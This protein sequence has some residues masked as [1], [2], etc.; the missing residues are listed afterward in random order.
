V[1]TV[2][3]GGDILE[4]KFNYFLMVWKNKHYKNISKSIKRIVGQPLLMIF[5]KK[6]NY[7]RFLRWV[8]LTVSYK[9]RYE[10][11]LRWVLLTISYKKPLGKVF[12]LGFA[13]GYL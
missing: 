7:E 10:K 8:L 9:N 2:T 6:N 13:N 5:Y 4:N 11:F 1:K 3:I 12:A